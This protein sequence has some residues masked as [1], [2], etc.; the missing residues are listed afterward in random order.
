MAKMMVKIYLEE[1]DKRK[2]MIKAEESGFSG[3]GSLSHYVSKVANSDLIFLDNNAR[4]I[5]KALNL[6][7]R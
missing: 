5:F 6:V 1:S 4:K 3:K 2:L 7:P